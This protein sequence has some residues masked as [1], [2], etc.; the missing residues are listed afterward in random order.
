MPPQ[1]S[2]PSLI[3]GDRQC[4]IYTETKT[5]DPEGSPV[6]IASSESPGVGLRSLRPA[7][8][9]GAQNATPGTDRRRRSAPVPCGTS[10]LPRH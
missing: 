7:S 6:F 3:P 4:R 2:M 9:R 1:Q 5:G 10:A 8:R